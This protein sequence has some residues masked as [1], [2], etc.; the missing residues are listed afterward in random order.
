MDERI[1]KRDFFRQLADAALEPDDPRYV[2]IY[3]DER[4]PRTTPSNSCRLRSSGQWAPAFSCSQGSAEAAKVLSCVGCVQTSRKSGYL[5]ILF[6]AEH[7]LN[8]SI[9]VDVPDFLLAVAGALGDSVVQAGLLPDD[10]AKVSYWRRFQA[11]L[12]SI[13]LEEFSVDVGVDPIKFG[14]KAN[15]RSD[16]EFTSQLQERMA[17]H[18]GRFIADVRSYVS[19]IASQ[20]LKTHPKALGITLIVD[21]VEHIRGIRRTRKKCSDQ[22]RVYLQCT[23]RSFICRAF[24][25]YIQY[26]HG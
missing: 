23:L 16:P 12:K 2:R 22:L 14:L 19:E 11:F 7:Y 21:S 20:I 10:P 13:N 3:D 6:D 9:P 26:L 1:F 17:G 5:V 15:L 4:S 18:L 8:L 25:L 24:I